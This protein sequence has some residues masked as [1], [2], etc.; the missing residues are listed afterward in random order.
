MTQIRNGAGGGGHRLKIDATNR[1]WIRS[2][3]ETEQSE[4]A[5]E[6]N[7]YI[8]SSGLITL[9]NASESALLYFKNS[10]TKPVNITRLLASVRNSTGATTSHALLNVYRAPTGLSGGSSGAAFNINF[11]S[12]KTLSGTVTKGA[13]GASITGGTL[14]A[15]ISTPTEDTKDEETVIIL[16]PGASIGISATPPAGNTSLQIGV[17]FSCHLSPL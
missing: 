2:V 6:G 16:P 1:G 5:K 13:Q 8:V 15:A 12:P 17:S 3:V 10:E 4:Q 7:A 9:T 11:N 14:V